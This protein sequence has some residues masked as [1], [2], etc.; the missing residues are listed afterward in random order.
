MRDW[1]R[2]PQMLTRT[3][4]DKNTLRQKSLLQYFEHNPRVRDAAVRRLCAKTVAERIRDAEK[5]AN[6]DAIVSWGKY[7]GHSMQALLKIAVGMNDVWL[8]VFSSE[9]RTVTELVRPDHIGWWLDDHVCGN[10]PRNAK[11]W[12]FLDP[13][14]LRLYLFLCSKTELA[15][16]QRAK[17]A[18]ARSHGQTRYRRERLSLSADAHDQYQRFCESLVPKSHKRGPAVHVVQD[19]EDDD[20]AP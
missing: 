14:Q 12:N 9:G 6:E 18:V 5:L 11:Q 2:P 10:K 7:R 3:Q 19:D 20:G 17:I 8:K 13:A 1:V 16:A 4:E 15:L